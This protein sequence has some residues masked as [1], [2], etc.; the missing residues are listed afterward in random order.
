MESDL[1][2]EGSDTTKV[3]TDEQESDTRLVSLGKVAPHIHAQNDKRLIRRF[4][5]NRRKEDVITWGGRLLDCSQFLIQ[6]SKLL[7]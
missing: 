2:S 1:R 4:G 5:R 3:G 6:D 7:L